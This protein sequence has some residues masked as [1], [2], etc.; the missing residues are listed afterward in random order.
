MKDYYSILGVA[1]TATA[2]EIRRAF[3]QLALRYHPDVD[4]SPEATD[5][6]QEINVA[7]QT[8]IDPVRRAEYDAARTPASSSSGPAPSEQQRAR[9][10]YFQRRVRAATDSRST[11]NYY[12]VLGIPRDATEQAVVRSYQLLYREFYHGSEVDPGTA[13]I[14]EEI[15]N[16]QEVLTDPAR[17]AAYDRIPPDQQPPGRPQQPPASTGRGRGRPGR[18]SPD[19]GKRTGCLPGLLLTPLAA[20]AMLVKRVISS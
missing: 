17:R 11:W 15:K 1:P 7:Y 3:R 19:A 5:R 12:D 16:A 8:L 4:G 6:F 18:R 2:V 13:S 20:L 9:H 14:L 10:A